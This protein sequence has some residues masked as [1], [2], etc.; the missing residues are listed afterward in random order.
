M[1]KQIVTGTNSRQAILR[2]VNI[3]GGCGENHA[4]PEGTQCGDREEVRRADHHQGRR[5][6][7][8]GNRIAGRRSKIWAR[9]W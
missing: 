5:D 7:R 9:R 3:L 8:E 4:G 2:G 6:G 1:A